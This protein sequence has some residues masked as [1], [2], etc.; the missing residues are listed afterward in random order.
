MEKLER[1]KQGNRERKRSRR[2]TK[3]QMMIPSVSL[4]RYW[5][6]KSNNTKKIHKTVIEMSHT[7]RPNVSRLIYLQAAHVAHF[8]H[9]W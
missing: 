9:G 5:R 7:I 2:D 1:E 3:T 8:G 6:D 4:K